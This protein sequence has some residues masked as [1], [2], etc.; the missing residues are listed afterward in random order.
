M[1]V[2]MKSTICGIFL[3]ASLAAASAQASNLSASDILVPSTQFFNSAN[4]HIYQVVNSAVTWT[5]AFNA[6]PLNSIR[7]V[8]GHLVTI[9]SASENAFVFNLI[10]STVSTG[11]DG[12]SVWLGASDAETEGVWKWVAGP[13]AGLEFWHGASNG[14]G[15][16]SVFNNMYAPYIQNESGA[17]GISGC[18]SNPTGTGSDSLFLYGGSYTPGFWDDSYSSLTATSN[19]SSPIASA[20]GMRNAYVIEYGADRR[21][22]RVSVPEPST[23][24]MLLLGFGLSGFALRRRVTVAST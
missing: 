7:G 24:A 6:A 16:P 3:A 11:W 19:S 1:G 23:W 17:C 14:S 2:Q 12:R 21:G 5:E 22:P 4:R 13:E 8:K 9:T 15:V 18:F 10:Q 20:D